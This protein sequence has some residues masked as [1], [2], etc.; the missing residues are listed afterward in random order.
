MSLPVVSLGPAT[1][2]AKVE[3]ASTVGTSSP[4][5]AVFH[6]P[7]SPRIAYTSKAAIHKL[8]SGFSDKIETSIS[9]SSRNSEGRDNMT[10]SVGADDDTIAS[11]DA[12]AY[13]IAHASSTSSSGSYTGG[14]C[15]DIG[16][17]CGRTPEM[18]EAEGIQQEVGKK[19]DRMALGGTTRGS[20]QVL[21]ADDVSINR[22]MTKRCL[23]QL[24]LDCDEAVDGFEAVAMCAIKR[25]RLVSN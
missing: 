23:E 8:G 22:K 13:D 10:G 18:Y 19:R 3:G 11:T 25:Y 17:R 6:P 1:E 16:G 24:G 12:S 5:Q 21:I 4:Q 9:S 15:H 20:A 14:G 7:A 2:P